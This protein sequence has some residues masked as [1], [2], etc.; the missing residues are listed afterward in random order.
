MKK[1][2][3]RLIDVSFCDVRGCKE[4]AFDKCDKC[5]KD[6]CGKHSHG[7]GCEPIGEGRYYSAVKTIYICGNCKKR[8]AD[9][10]S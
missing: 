4:E 9:N 8:E 5:G 3:K 10:V 7:N 2:R 1:Q 6:I